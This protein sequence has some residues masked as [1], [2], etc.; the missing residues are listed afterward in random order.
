MLRSDMI[1]AN[2]EASA[3]MAG[4]PVAISE[5]SPNKNLIRHVKIH[6]INAAGYRSIDNQ[7]HRAGERRWTDK[8][9][10]RTA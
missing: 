4:H 10:D 7:A 1:S 8:W 2:L 5:F 9:T 3:A 6:L